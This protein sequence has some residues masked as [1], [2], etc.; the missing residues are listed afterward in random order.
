MRRHLGL[1]VLF[2]I[3]FS[4]L[5]SWVYAQ[6]E[7]PINDGAGYYLSR[8]DIVVDV[9]KTVH[10]IWDNSYSIRYKYKPLNGSWSEEKV[11]LD[12][13]Q[14]QYVGYPNIGVDAEGKA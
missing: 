10:V 12:K 7:G 3:N 2:I 4:L 5:C 1:L 11:V 13:Y 14:G 9:N 8:P 6:E